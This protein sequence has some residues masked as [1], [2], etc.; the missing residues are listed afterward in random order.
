[1]L[2]PR[3]SCFD[4]KHSSTLVNRLEGKGTNN[5]LQCIFHRQVK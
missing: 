1:M 5:Y 2:M 3:F 4:K